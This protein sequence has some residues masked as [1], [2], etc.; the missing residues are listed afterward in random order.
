MFLEDIVEIFL[1]VIV[2]IFLPACSGITNKLLNRSQVDIETAYSLIST[3]K[4]S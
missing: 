2:K 4:Y 1:E 3:Q